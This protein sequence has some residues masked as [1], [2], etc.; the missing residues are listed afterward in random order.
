MVEEDPNQMPE[1]L[2][3]PVYVQCFI[4]SYHSGKVITRSSHSGILLLVKN[5]LTKSFRKRQNTVKSITFGSDLVA[6]RIARGM[7]V[8]IRINMEIFGVP[9]DG[10]ENVFCY[11]N[12]EAKNTSIPEYIFSDKHNIIN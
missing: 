10:P 12:G 7:I 11:N 1:F 2:G 4:D 3:N 5:A 6:L 9:L 8:E